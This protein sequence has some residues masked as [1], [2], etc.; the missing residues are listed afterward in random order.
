MIYM[1]QVQSLL[2]LSAW[3]IEEGKSTPETAFLDALALEKR[4]L[5]AMLDTCF[6][7]TGPELNTV[8]MVSDALPT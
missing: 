3:L 2:H 8:G 7:Q 1:Q 6:K 4:H 5:H